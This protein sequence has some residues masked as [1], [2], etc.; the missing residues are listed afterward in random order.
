MTTKLLCCFLTLVSICFADKVT[1]SRTAASELYAALA[2]T[3]AGLSPSNTVIAADN[4]NALRPQVE[5]L[6]KGKSAYQR[7][8]RLLA[9]S[10]SS[11]VDGKA[12]S[13]ADDIEAKASEEVDFNLTPMAFSDDEITNAKIKPAALAAIRRHLLKVSAATQPVK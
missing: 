8:F 13:L 2:S 1:L 7:A 12:Q 10:N 4:L 11:D 5:A 9:K 6:D 3:E